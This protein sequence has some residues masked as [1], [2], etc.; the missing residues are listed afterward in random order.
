MGDKTERVEKQSEP[1][2]EEDVTNALMKI[3]KGEQKTIYFTA[4]HG[5]KQSIAPT[6]RAMSIAEAATSKRK[7]TSLSR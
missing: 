2:R 5:E 7:T 4:G 1:V 3:V 6:R